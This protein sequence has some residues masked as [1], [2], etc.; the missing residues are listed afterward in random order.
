MKSSTLDTKM[1]EPAEEELFRDLGENIGDPTKHHL[2]SM[3]REGNF[4]DYKLI[5]NEKVY[6][7]HKVILFSESLYFQ[8]LFSVQWESLLS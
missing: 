2:Y 6:T 7:V 1:E 4:S 8:A 5:W 3:L